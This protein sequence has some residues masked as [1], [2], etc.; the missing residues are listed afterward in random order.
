ML[1]L[2]KVLALSVLN[3]HLFLYITMQSTRQTNARLSLHK[4]QKHH[5]EAHKENY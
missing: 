4:C 5:P 2:S 1:V 3:A